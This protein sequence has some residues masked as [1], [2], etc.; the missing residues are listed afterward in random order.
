[1]AAIPLEMTLGLLGNEMIN[2]YLSRKLF[3]SPTNCLSGCR[4]QE[5]GDTSQKTSI[6][7]NGLCLLE[8]RCSLLAVEG[9]RHI[10][11]GFPM[12]VTCR[13]GDSAVTAT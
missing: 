8:C 5:K 7:R 13:E 6:F 10:T 1:M 2:K 9:T 12:L 4:R 3:P 11:A